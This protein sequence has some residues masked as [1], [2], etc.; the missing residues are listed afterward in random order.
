MK[1]AHV[2]PFY[3][4][5]IC[6]V[7]NVVEELARYQISEGNEVHVFTSDWDKNKRIEKKYEMLDNVHVH[8]SFHLVKFTNFVSLWPSVFLELI[9]ENFDIIHTH[10]FGHPHVV[11]AALVARIRHIPH[12]HTTHCPW[13][14]SYRSLIARMGVV[15]SYNL[16]S[17]YVL[18]HTEQIIAI[19]PWEIDFIKKYGG[20]AEK[21]SVLPNGMSSLFFQRIAKNNFKKKHGIRGNLV[22]FFGRLNVTKGPDRFV[23]IAHRVLQER[24]KTFFVIRGPDEGMKKRVQELISGEKRIILLEPTRERLDAVRMYQAADIFVLPSYREGLPLTLFEAMA[25]SLPIVATPV[26]GVPYEMKEPDNGFLVP[27]GDNERFAQR[28][29]T[30]LDNRS[31]RRTIGKRNKEKALHYQWEDIAR[32]TMQ[33]YFEAIQKAKEKR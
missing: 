16:V 21:I 30:L 31:L 23:E 1:I 3:T 12:I 8:R 27:Y 19:T 4:P 10:E 20:A 11:L 13:S 26:N 14:D 18:A 6:G 5:T 17:R 32:R 22:L 33:F 2:C 25:S 28:I 15:V 24:P 29:I 9:D 7:K